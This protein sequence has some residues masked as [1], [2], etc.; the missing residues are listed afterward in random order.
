VIGTP[1]TLLFAAGPA[2][3]QHGLFGTITAAKRGGH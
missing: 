2:D 1:H 3:E